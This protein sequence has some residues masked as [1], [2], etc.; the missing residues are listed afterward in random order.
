MAAVVERAVAAKVVE[1][2]VAATA[3]GMAAVKAVARAEAA[4]EVAV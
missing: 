2:T 1:V 3:V 4:M